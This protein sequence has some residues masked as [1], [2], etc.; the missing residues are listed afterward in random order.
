MIVEEG[1]SMDIGSNNETSD[2]GDK[3][4]RKF[5][6][7]AYIDLDFPMNVMSLAYYNAIRNQEYEHRGLNFVGIGNDMHAG[8]CESPLDLED[9]FYK[10]I[11]KHGPD[12]NWKIERLDLEGPLEAKNSRI[13]RGVMQGE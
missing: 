12:Y 9:G 7:N 13:S 8:G 10:D 11:D 3:A 1:E 5:I 2:L 4:W 6:A